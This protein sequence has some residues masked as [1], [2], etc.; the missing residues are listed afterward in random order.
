MDPGRQSRLLPAGKFDWHL[1]EFLSGRHWIPVP[2]LESPAIEFW[3]RGIKQRCAIW[4]QQQTETFESRSNILTKDRQSTPPPEKS[5]VSKFFLIFLKKSFSVACLVSVGAAQLAHFSLIILV[6]HFSLHLVAGYLCYKRAR[7][8][9]K[10][11]RR[12]PHKKRGSS[13]CVRCVCVRAVS[14]VLCL[15]CCC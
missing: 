11:K 9:N 14:L 15:S 8:N 2:F 13:N 5:V 7:R 3:N 4:T 1:V 6:S 10:K 12:E